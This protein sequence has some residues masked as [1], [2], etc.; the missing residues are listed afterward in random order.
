[1]AIIIL[2]L[3]TSLH[4]TPFLKSITP[5]HSTTAKTPEYTDFS[6][7]WTSAKCMGYEMTLHIENSWDYLR[8]EN[9]EMTIGT[10]ETTSTS[11]KTGLSSTYATS[12]IRSAEWNEDK[13][14]L[15]LKSISVDKKFDMQEE[16]NQSIDT[17]MNIDM[18]FITLELNNAELKLKINSVQYK[19]AQ[20]VDVA[21]PVCVFTQVQ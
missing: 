17:A 3:S 1:M 14:K 15:L 7:T 2:G 19:D 18:D 12:D 6:G 4:A 8:I 20:R 13:T 10:M 5:Q 9:D 16:H 21:Q 11:G